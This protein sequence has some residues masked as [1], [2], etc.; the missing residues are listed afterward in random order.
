MKRSGLKKT[1]GV[2][3]V[4]TII[5]ALAL[6]TVSFGQGQLLR[7][8]A[9]K[10]NGYHYSFRVGYQN[11]SI[12]V[13]NELVYYWYDNGKIHE[14][15]GGYSGTLL[16]GI[17]EKDTYGGQLLEKGRF[18]NGLKDEEWKRWDNQGRLVEIVMWDKGMRDGTYRAFDNEKNRQIVAE[19]KKNRLH[20]WKMEYRGDSLFYKEKYRD[21]KKLEKKKL[22]WFKKKPQKGTDKNEE[23]KLKKR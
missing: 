4:A 19:Y 2:K 12:K 3:C 5:L 17:F 21:G 10:G 16:Q 13:K 22:L 11:E 7:K 20:G 14:N 18:E 6:S 23:E 15:T 9:Y 1:K 8:I